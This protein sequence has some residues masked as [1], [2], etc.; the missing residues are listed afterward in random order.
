MS[1]KENASTGRK[2]TSCS[3][4][5]IPTRSSTSISTSIPRSP[6]SGAPSSTCRSRNTSRPICSRW[7]T[8]RISRGRLRRKRQPPAVLPEAAKA[9]VQKSIAPV[10]RAWTPGSGLALGGALG[11]QSVLEHV[12][13]NLIIVMRLAGT[14]SVKEITRDYIAPP[15]VA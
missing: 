13:N 1:S 10:V 11:V 2:A 8:R 4:H 15:A 6:R 9:A 14:N 5:C 3:C 12:R 7:K